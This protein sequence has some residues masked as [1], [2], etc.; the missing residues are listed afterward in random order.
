MMIFVARL[1]L[2][3]VFAV[4]A[5]GKLADQTAREAVRALRSPLKATL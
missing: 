4:A 5:V 1:I 3:A 2:A